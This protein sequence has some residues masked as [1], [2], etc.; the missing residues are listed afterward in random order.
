MIKET[1]EKQIISALKGGDDALLNCLK[2]FKADYTKIAI[3]KRCE[4][5][6]E[7]IIDVAAK[8]IKQYKDALETL[9]KE[10]PIYT[11][12][13]YRIDMLSKYLP[14][15]LTPDEVV[16]MVIEAKNA[17]GS[18]TVKDIGKMMKVLQP[19][20]KGRFDGKLLASIVNSVLQ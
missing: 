6:D 4:V 2:S 14:A 7:V 12:Y 16:A 5:T 10:S 1:I 17:T 15:Q 18:S 8:S 3:D 11:D 9:P 19:K 13:E 20:V